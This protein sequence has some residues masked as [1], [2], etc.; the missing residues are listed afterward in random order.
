NP[1]TIVAGVLNTN[2]SCYNTIT[3]DLVVEQAPVIF[4]P[5]ALEYCDPDS[6]G[7]GVFT[8]TD[9]DAQITGGAPGLTVT[10]HETPADAQ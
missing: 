4:T 9:A 6:D 3:L 2:T 10:Y 1:Q 7:F 5:T 8:L